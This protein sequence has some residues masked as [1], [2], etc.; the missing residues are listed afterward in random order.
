MGD[1]WNIYQTCYKSSETYKSKILEGSIFG[2]VIGLKIA[3]H[4]LN[5]DCANDKVTNV[6]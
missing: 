4:D 2:M 1:F 5:K 3:L 6:W